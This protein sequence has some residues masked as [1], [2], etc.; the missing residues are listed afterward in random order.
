[1]LPAQ[2]ILPNPDAAMCVQITVRRPN[3][4][5]KAHGTSLLASLSKISG[6]DHCCRTAVDQ[7]SVHAGNGGEVTAER[8]TGIEIGTGGAERR[9]V[10]GTAATV[11]GMSASGIGACPPMAAGMPARTGERCCRQLR[12]SYFGTAASMQT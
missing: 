4:K 3:L 9:G 8:G 5:S 1:M 10:Q 7:A 11:C 12:N 2:V 6:T